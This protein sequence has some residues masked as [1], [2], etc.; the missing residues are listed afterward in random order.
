MFL[1]GFEPQ[2]PASERPLTDALDRTATGIGR[3]VWLWSHYQLCNYVTL[4][5]E[6]RTYCP[7]T[8]KCDVRVGYQCNAFRDYGCRHFA[9]TAAKTKSTECLR[10][11]GLAK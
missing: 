3:A 2:I 10:R 9:I 1:A 6:V 4:E 7:C 5:I 8:C 11:L